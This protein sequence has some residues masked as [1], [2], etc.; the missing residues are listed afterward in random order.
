L[1]FNS[2]LYAMLTNTKQLIEYFKDNVNIAIA[3]MD[4]AKW[5]TVG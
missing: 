1:L 3:T 5:V 4:A 2:G